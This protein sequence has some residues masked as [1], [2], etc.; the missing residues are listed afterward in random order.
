[1]PDPHAVP[2]VHEIQMRVDLQDMDRALTGKGLDAGDI[3]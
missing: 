3:H 2:L 1:M